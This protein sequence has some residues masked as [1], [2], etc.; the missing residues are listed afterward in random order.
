MTR[1][2]QI[3]VFGVM[4]LFTYNETVSHFLV[5]DIELTE[6]LDV[7][8]DT[9]EKDEFDEKENNKLIHFTLDSEEDLNQLSVIE[10]GYLA[11]IKSIM[12]Q[13]VPSPPP[14]LL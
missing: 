13:K 1:I 14:D 4:I 2:F 12:V 6:S 11:I 8:D 3:I 9:D 10:V 7:E 5:D